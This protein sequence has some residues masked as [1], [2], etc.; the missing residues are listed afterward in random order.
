MFTVKVLIIPLQPAAVLMPTV[1]NNQMWRKFPETMLAKATTTLA[2]RRG[3][4]DVIAGIASADEMD[5]AGL[6]N[7]EALVQGTPVAASKTAPQTA[8][9]PLW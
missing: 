8:P 7:P 1:K 9:K 5:Q 6:A 4:A 3:F 2:L